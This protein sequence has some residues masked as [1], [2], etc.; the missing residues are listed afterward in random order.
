MLFRG[1]TSGIV[2]LAYIGSVQPFDV[3]PLYLGQQ[4]V[5]SSTPLES[6]H[7]TSVYM[8]TCHTDFCSQGRDLVGHL[9]KVPV[10]MITFLLWTLW[11]CDCLDGDNCVSLVYRE[12]N[13]VLHQTRRW[14][15]LFRQGTYLFVISGAHIWR[16]V[17]IRN[18]YLRIAEK[19]TLWKREILLL[20]KGFPGLWFPLRH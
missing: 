1:I 11:L 2:I 6:H 19:I 16:V 12:R 9:S 18:Y 8:D 5:L 7:Q 10:C 3:Q 20:Q 15:C 13:L 17:W 14:L 4:G